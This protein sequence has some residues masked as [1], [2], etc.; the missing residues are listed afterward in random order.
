MPYKIFVT[1]S[2]PDA[3][4]KLLQANKNVSLDIYERDQQ[5]PRKE[6]LRRVRGADII[7]SILTERMDKEV[8]DAAGP[9]L[10]MIANYAV[11]FDN[12]DVKEAARRKI[13]VTNTP[14]ERVNE[15][16]AW[17]K[18]CWQNDG[19]C[20]NGSHWIIR[21]QTSSRWIRY[22]DSLF[23][24]ESQQRSRNNNRSKISYARET[25]RRI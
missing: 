14:H 2:I 19:N 23:R 17:Y 25:S 8:M 7:L 1:R 15:S 22:E 11:G 9:Q 4:I 3:G 13:V 24:F 21:R 16:V 6:L 20:W 10:K 12:V 5:I 18:S